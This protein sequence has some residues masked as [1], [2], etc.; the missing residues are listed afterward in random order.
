MGCDYYIEKILYITLINGDIL[1]IKLSSEKGYFIHDYLDED[2]P[3]YEEK[4]Q[5]LIEESLTPEMEPIIIFKK[6][7]NY[8]NDLFY[9][10]YHSVIEQCII[11][12][13]YSMEDILIIKK[14]E[15]RNERI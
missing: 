2:E 12:H 1:Y 7:Q 3:G 6:K 5:K 14:V 11:R 8:L 15:E 13:N 10:R 4:V 9:E